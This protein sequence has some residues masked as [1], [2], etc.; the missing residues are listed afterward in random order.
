MN[1]TDMALML[2]NLPLIGRERSKKIILNYQDGIELQRLIRIL[3]PFIH[4][5][6][7]DLLNAWF[8][9]EE[10]KRR[11]GESGIEILA[12][13]DLAF[14]FRFLSLSD[15]PLLIFI[16][17]NKELLNCRKSSAV[18]GSRFSG[19]EILNLTEMITRHLLIHNFTIISGLALGCDS[20]A[21]R[22]ALVFKGF[23]SAVMPCGIDIIYPEDNRKLYGEILNNRGLII[24]EYGMS[25]QP[26]PFR[27]VERDRLQ[28]GLSDLVVVM[29]TA[30]NGGTMH[31]AISALKQKRTVLVYKPKVLSAKNSGNR[32]L[33]NCEKVISFSDF[34][35]F[36]EILGAIPFICRDCNRDS[37]QLLFPYG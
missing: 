23:T 9:G 14:P 31:T 7:S 17:G 2:L 10:Q 22:T 26:A 25:I 1:T 20:V 35:E 36:A 24:S 27:F 19:T 28:S 12:F 37:D 18:I 33:I 4:V 32:K 30:V 3:Y 34:D 5:T 15:K 16:K 29:E 21:H 8:M 13:D 11:I 6:R